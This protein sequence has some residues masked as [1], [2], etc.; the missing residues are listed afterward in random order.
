M[1]EFYG[2]YSDAEVWRE[3]K[4]GKE[5]AFDYIFDQYVRVLFNYSRKFTDDAG[6]IEDCIQD[7]FV[8]LWEKKHLL[9]DTDS[10]KFYLFKSMR[11]RIVR[12]LGREKRLGERQEPAD[13]SHFQAIDSHE[14][15]LIAG[16]ID[17]EQRKALTEA[18]ESLSKRQREALFLKYFDDL[19][20]GQIAEIM[21]IGV[22]SV[23]KL[24]SGAL[25]TLKKHTRKVYLF[26]LLLGLG[27]TAFGA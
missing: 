25:A 16:Q 6:L 13:A 1:E 8:E 3:F 19:S 9:G 5:A 27:V 21:A 26:L 4:S 10:I 7:L 24:I 12:V 17:A 15:S 20:Y 2:N 14:F 23:Y 22:D 11:L 18:M